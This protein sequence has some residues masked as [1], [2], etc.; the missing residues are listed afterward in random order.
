MT[1]N[2][3][4]DL[5]KELRKGEK[6]TCPICGE[7]IMEPIGKRETTKGFRCTECKKGLSIN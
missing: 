3:L 4:N 7:G 1:P 5:V 6:V 2:E